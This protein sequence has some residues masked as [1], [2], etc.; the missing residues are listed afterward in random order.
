MMA[1]DAPRC[2]EAV[3][4]TVADAEQLQ[5]QLRRN[6][7]KTDVPTN[8][9]TTAGRSRLRWLLRR[10]GRCSTE[11]AQTIYRLPYTRARS[12]TVHVL[13]KVRAAPVVNI[14]GDAATV[15]LARTAGGGY[16]HWP[17]CGSCGREGTGRR[18]TTAL[19]T[20]AA[21]RSATIEPVTS[22]ETGER[23]LSGDRRWQ[24]QR[25]RHNCCS[26][27]KKGFCQPNCLDV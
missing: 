1:L 11:I 19:E 6:S 10:G 4:Q 24:Q 14:R 5:L 13:A 20:R 26:S 21:R 12:A 18:R 23:R 7:T 17:A 3:D 2:K 27:G 16:V 25:W 22:P 15:S 9:A 8:N